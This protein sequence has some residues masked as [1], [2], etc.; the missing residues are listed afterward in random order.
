[1]EHSFNHSFTKKNT[2]PILDPPHQ[3][4]QPLSPFDYFADT[5]Q[6][7]GWFP[8]RRPILE[9]VCFLHRWTQ[10]WSDVWI[11]DFAELSRHLLSSSGER[12]RLKMM[13]KSFLTPRRIFTALK[14][15]VRFWKPQWHSRHRLSWTLRLRIL[16][17]LR[18][19]NPRSFKE[20][21]T[22]C[23]TL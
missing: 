9:L 7:F 4:Q 18:S 5:E 10:P 15:S 2:S 3:T 13:G 8:Y 16:C 20:L 1:M 6:F 21:R 12:Y 11:L 22:H 17:Q 14:I 19:Q 23:H